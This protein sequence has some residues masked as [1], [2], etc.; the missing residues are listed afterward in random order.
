LSRQTLPYSVCSDGV[1]FWIML[2]TTS[3]LARF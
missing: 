3:Q 1:N 2:Q